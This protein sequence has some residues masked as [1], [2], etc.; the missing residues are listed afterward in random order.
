[1]YCCGVRRNAFTAGLTRICVGQI[2][3][4]FLQMIEKPNSREK[5]NNDSHTRLPQL[6][7][8]SEKSRR[9]RYM[10]GDNKMEKALVGTLH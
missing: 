1:M 7:E 10:R 4:L 2:W 3:G 5:Q 6:W 8:G 9:S